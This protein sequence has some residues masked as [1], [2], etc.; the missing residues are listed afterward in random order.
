MNPD[1]ESIGSI[2]RELIQEA[3]RRPEESL[4]KSTLFFPA[5]FIASRKMSFREISVWLKD[6]HGVELSPMSISRALRSPKTHLNRLAE[7]VF[8]KVAFVSMATN[9]DPLVLLY[10]NVAPGAP[11]E[12][13]ML[14]HAFGHP[15]SAEEASLRHEIQSLNTFWCDLPYEV[16]LMLKPYI[17]EHIDLEEAATEDN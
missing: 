10:E 5:V 12:I 1:Y 9:Q 4:P 3:N 6:N 7:Y 16:R 13:T 2:S 8:R 15:E 11:L 14:A 17:E